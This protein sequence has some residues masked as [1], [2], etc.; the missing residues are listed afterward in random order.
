MYITYS[1]IPYSGPVSSE[2]EQ[3]GSACP[4]CLRCL[5]KRLRGLGLEFRLILDWVAVKELKLRDQNVY[6]YMHVVVNMVCPI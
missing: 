4:G 3:S 1:H 5:A 6:T 2:E